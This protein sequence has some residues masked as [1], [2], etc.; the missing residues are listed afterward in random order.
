[1]NSDHSPHPMAHPVDI[2]EQ[3]DARLAFISAAAGAFAGM[4]EGMRPQARAWSGLYYITLDMLR[5][6]EDV[7]ER[8]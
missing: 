4:D 2:W 7:R 6:A 5:M 1:M 8:L 3:V